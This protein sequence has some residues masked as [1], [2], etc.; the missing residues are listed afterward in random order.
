MTQRLVLSAAAVFI[1]AAHGPAFG[2]V[3]TCIDPAT[4]ART[5]SQFACPQTRTPSPAESA[6]SAEEQRLAAIKAQSERQAV[7]ADQQL[8]RKYPDAAAHQKARA[9][10]L[11]GVIRNI[12]ASAT[13]FSEL[14]QQRKPLNDEAAFYKGRPLPLPLQRKIEASDASFDALTDVFNGLRSEVAEIEIRRNNELAD[15]RL[16]WAGARRSHGTLAMPAT[17]SVSK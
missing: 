9:A 1:A 16:L 5:L 7:I 8:V 6:A 17:L 3:N 12:R 13:R 11:D 10:E 15:L 14:T 4:R 2:T